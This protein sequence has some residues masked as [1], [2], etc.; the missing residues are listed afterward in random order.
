[1]TIPNGVDPRRLVSTRGRD[2]TRRLLG[3]PSNAAVVLSIGAL[4]WEKDPLAHVEV[5]GRLLGEI[6]GLVHVM[7]GDGPMRAKVENAIVRQGVRD[8][9]LSLG[10]RDDVP[11]LLAASDVVLLASRSEGMP[12]TLIEAGMAGLPVAAYAVA[13]VPEVVADGITGLLAAPGD[14][15]GLADCVLRLLRDPRARNAMGRAARTRCLTMFDIEL[16]AP[17][18]RAIYEAVQ[19]A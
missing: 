14:A 15:D 11:D 17:Q 3:I 1:V 9:V 13:G 19:A 4:T 8:R 5:G 12:A 6:D 16:I 18:Y 2:A 7:V 10:S